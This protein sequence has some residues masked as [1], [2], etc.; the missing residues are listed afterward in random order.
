MDD[1]DFEK[2]ETSEAYTGNA[3]REV[4]TLLIAKAVTVEDCKAIF[5]V[6]PDTV[7]KSSYNESFDLSE[8]IS[9][10]IELVRGLRKEVFNPDGTLKEE[11]GI[12]SA[13]HILT[14]SRDLT[15]MLQSS[16]AELV[17]YKRIQAIET[18]FLDTI[19]EMPKEAQEKYAE[20]LGIYL[21]TQS[22]D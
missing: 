10:Q 11:Y 9:C 21:E 5:S 3:I 1:F 20:L 7:K 6:L 2:K 19:A 8:E 18:A 12:D 15:K 17:N 14:A 13:K 16:H 22:P 4:V